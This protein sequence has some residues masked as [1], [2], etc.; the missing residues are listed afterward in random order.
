MEII[1]KRAESQNS[2]TDSIEMVNGPLALFWHIYI[3]ISMAMG[4]GG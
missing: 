3:Y 2:Q 1:P 4:A